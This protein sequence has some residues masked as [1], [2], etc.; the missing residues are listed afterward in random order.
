MNKTRAL[1]GIILCLSLLTI[2]FFLAGCSVFGHSGVDVAPYN[3]LE[4][5]PP[6]ELRHYDSM[7]LVSTEMTGEAE[8]KDAFYRLFD[9]I[10]GENAAR[11]KI[12]M[13]APVF[14]DYENGKRHTMAFVMPF[15]FTLDTTPETQNPLVTREEITD[16]TVA[17]IQFSGRLTSDAVTKHQLELEAW[18][19]KQGYTIMGE[20]KA[21]GYNPP[22]TIPALRRNEVLIPVIKP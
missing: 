11:Q 17:A 2:S 12:P 20:A 3:V 22:F 18:I 16:Y 9:Y 6:F 7:V 13:T 5:Q 19:K 1:H 14:M 4:S 15:S 21:A 10:S 8:D